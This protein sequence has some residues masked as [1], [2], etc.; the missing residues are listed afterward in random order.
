MEHGGDLSEAMRQHGGSLDQ[1]L[2]LSTGINPWPWPIP[3][4]LSAAAWQRLPSHD[5]EAALIAA[6][7]TAYRVPQPMAIV[8]GPGTQALIQWLP[9]LALP[10]SVAI[11][12]PTYGGHAAAWVDSG[13][14]VTEIADL[15]Q[16]PDAA[17]HAVV[18]NPNNPDGRV[19][20]RAALA[21]AAERLQSRAG[22]L[23]VD[24]SFADLD[25]GIGAA[26]LAAELPVIVLRSFGKFYGLA[27]V[28]L[29]FAIAAP[30]NA[31]R[32]AAAVGRWAVSGPALA[33]GSAALADT[34]WA[35]DMRERLAWEA[36]RLDAVLAAA[37]LPVIGGTALYRLVRHPGAAAIHEAL[38]A[39]HIWCRQFAW[40]EDLLRFGLAPDAA[41]LRRLSAAITRRDPPARNT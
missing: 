27:G 39:Q 4:A 33:I 10:G 41:A 9:R 7:R 30:D 21:R 40:A 12:G 2:D 17:R 1:W 31:N 34:S 19:K 16:L 15:E 35:A 26:D 37:G 38:A 20:D 22:W 13:H 32:V 11:V 14:A 8:A 18:V 28:R 29:G 5:D 24:E 23:V 6:A 3:A 25:S 36:G